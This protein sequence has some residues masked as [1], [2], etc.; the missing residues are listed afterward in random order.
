MF[1]LL[2]ACHLNG[3]YN[4][5]YLIIIIITNK[6]IKKNFFCY[7]CNGFLGVVGQGNYR[8]PELYL[9]QLLF[10]CLVHT[11]HNTL[12]VVTNHVTSHGIQ[13]L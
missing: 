2:H 11:V 6:N 12:T 13:S 9:T 4:L 8:W 3:I 5:L 10:N 7:N 1:K